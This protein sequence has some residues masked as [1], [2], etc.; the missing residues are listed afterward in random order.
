MKCCQTLS[1]QVLRYAGH[2]NTHVRISVGMSTCKIRSVLVNLEAK[3]FQL[4]SRL[5]SNRCLGCGRLLLYNLL[6]R[7]IAG[8]AAAAMWGKSITRHSLHTS[9]EEIV[10]KYRDAAAISATIH[11][12]TVDLFALSVGALL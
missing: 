12:V 4:H 2:R 7:A 3:R 10:L 1:L 11:C 9:I 6:S 8:A 5:T